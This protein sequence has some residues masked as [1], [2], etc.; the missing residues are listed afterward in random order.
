MDLKL[1]V[2]DGHIKSIENGY[3]KA[4]ELMNEVENYK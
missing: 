1:T 2:S 3:L 4:V